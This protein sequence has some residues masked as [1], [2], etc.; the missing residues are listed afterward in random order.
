[1][2]FSLTGLQYLVV[3]HKGQY[4]A[5]CSLW[6]IND[7]EDRISNNTRVLKF[8]DDT[9]VSQRVDCQK[10]QEILQKDLDSFCRWAKDWQ[11]TFNISKCKV[12]HVGKKNQVLDYVMEGLTLEKSPGLSTAKKKFQDK[13]FHKFQDTWQVI[14]R[15][16]AQTRVDNGL[17]KI[18]K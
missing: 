10:E 4:W 9:K 2:E 8:A 1:M 11:M 17:Q 18:A 7:L 12:M 5:H 16:H 13:N 15:S 6:Y 14:G 3:Y